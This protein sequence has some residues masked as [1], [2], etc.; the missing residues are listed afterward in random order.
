MIQ[1]RQLLTTGAAALASLGWGSA[2]VG[3]AWAQ[4]AP[5]LGTPELPANGVRRIGGLGHRA[6]C[7]M[8]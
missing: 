2:L 3:P 8:P 1:R 6:E 4:N 7:G 5:D